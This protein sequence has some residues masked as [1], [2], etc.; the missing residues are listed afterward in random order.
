M[1]I[2]H[3]ELAGSIAFLGS[4]TL[5]LLS[6]LTEALLSLPTVVSW[7]LLMEA[8][9][10]S[11]RGALQTTASTLSLMAAWTNSSSMPSPYRKKHTYVVNY[12][13]NDKEKAHTRDP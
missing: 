1:H 11:L 2:A 9:L 13:I 12:T 7:T 4:E 8:L 6:L 5:T 3:S 10:S